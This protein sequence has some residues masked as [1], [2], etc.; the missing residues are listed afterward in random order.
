MSNR[1]IHTI[2]TKAV[3]EAATEEGKKKME[4]QAAEDVLTQG[5]LI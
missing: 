5:G 2:Y 3:N 1:L 4:A